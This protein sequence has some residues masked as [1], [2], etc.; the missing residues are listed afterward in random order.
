MLRGRRGERSML[1]E[2]CV[3]DDDVHRTLFVRDS[4]VKTVEIR[5]ICHVAHEPYSHFYLWR[6]WP[7]QFTLTATGDEDVCALLTKRCAARCCRL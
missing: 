5:E 2:A 7:V 1:D 6:L 4:F 3:G